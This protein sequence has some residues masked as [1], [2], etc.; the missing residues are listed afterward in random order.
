LVALGPDET[1]SEPFIYDEV[2]RAG[3]DAVVV[4]AYYFDDAKQPR[5]YLRSATRPPVVLRHMTRPPI[6][7]L[8]TRLGLW[9]LV[10]GIVELDESH[11]AGIVDCARRELEE[12]LGF[13]VDSSAMLP[14][15]TSTFPAPGVIG[16]R[17][18]FFQVEVDP[19]L[20]GQPSLD[21]SPLERLGAIVDVTLSD[22]L[23]ACANGEIEDSKTELGLRRLAERLGCA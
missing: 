14:L 18:F 13:Q 3:I 7:G 4:A 6:E 19:E 2:D 12:E 15:G 10:A 16:E 20:R 9:E 17:H 8:A 22:A 23:K 5:V 11:P 1:S 21:G